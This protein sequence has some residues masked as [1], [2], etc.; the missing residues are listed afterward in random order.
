MKDEEC[1]SVFWGFFVIV[2]TCT[3]NPTIT[4]LSIFFKCTST[5]LFTSDTLY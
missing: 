2:F 5:S 3:H 1:I 4:G